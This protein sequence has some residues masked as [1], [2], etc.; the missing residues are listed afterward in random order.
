MK[1]SLWVRYRDGPVKELDPDSLIISHYLLAG[2]F[3]TLLM[4][5]FNRD[6][7][8]WCIG[9]R[10]DTQ[11]GISGS[12]KIFE[13]PSKAMK[14]ELTEETGLVPTR[15]ISIVGKFKSKKDVSIGM[16]PISF[17]RRVA[18]R[19][20][21]KRLPDHDHKKVGVLLVGNLAEMLRKLRDV[22]FET[23]QEDTITH[24]MVIHRDDAK[25]VCLKT[26]RHK[27]KCSDSM[28]SFTPFKVTIHRENLTVSNCQQP[29][30]KLL[31]GSEP[32][33][34]EEKKSGY[35]RKWDF[36]RFLVWLFLLFCLIVFC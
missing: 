9:Y 18:L 3:E 23:I 19:S 24:F 30:T 6:K 32:K 4:N 10:D 29:D 20:V 2:V 12:I 5:R 11:I 15:K 22:N 35:K 17:T 27:K 7:W 36:K 14:R 28:C 33:S 26:F 1:H 31:D 25:A 21:C 16:L 8:L 13:S 34:C